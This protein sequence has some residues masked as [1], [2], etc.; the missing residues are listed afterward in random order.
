MIGDRAAKPIKARS[1]ATGHPN[2]VTVFVDARRD[3]PAETTAEI[4]TGPRVGPDTLEQI[5]CTGTVSVISMDGTTPI[6]TSHATRPIPPALRHAI[7]HRDG[8]CTIDGCKSRYR[9]QPHHIQRWSDSGG[10]NPTNLTT[11][12]WYHHHIA[13]HGQ[14][15]EIDPVPLSRGTAE[16]QG[17]DAGGSSPTPPL[18]RRLR[19][20][21]SG[22]DPPSGPP[23][24]VH[25]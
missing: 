5:L 9:L 11:L 23:R 1:Q 18:R 7:V 8:G 17:D 14:G 19:R 15:Y 24:A 3:N 10:H 13:I 16:E 2:H 25:R 21:R 22:T 6:A 20:R 12:C 4:A